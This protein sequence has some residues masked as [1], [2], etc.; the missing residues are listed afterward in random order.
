M[1]SVHSITVVACRK[2]P[3]NAGDYGTP[4]ENEA[5]SRPR[6][7]GG[8]VACCPQT[9]AARFCVSMSMRLWHRSDVKQSMVGKNDSPRP[10]TS[11][12]R[13]ANVGYTLGERERRRVGVRNG[14]R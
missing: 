14:V 12:D 8:H 11:P 2:V 13:S 7:I 9:G 4:R 6:Q 1:I 3:P 10:D 5:S